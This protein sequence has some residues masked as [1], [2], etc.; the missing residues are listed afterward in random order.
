MLLPS[1]SP[2]ALALVDLL[3]VAIAVFDPG[4]KAPS[5]ANVAW[6]A[7][8]AAIEIDDV[9][10]IG[11]AHH[12]SECAVGLGRTPAYC[13]ATVRP[14]GTRLIVACE[15]I[16]D[17]VI[18]RQLAVPATA[19]VWGGPHAG[20]PDY[21]NQRW[22]AYVGSDPSWQQAIHRDDLAVCTKALAAALREEGST[23]VEARVCAANGLDRW[24]RV[25]FA[26]AGSR[27]VGTAVD[28]HDAHARAERDELL[29]RLSAA[30]ADAETASRLKDQFLAVV[31][32]ELRTPLTTIVL[33]EGILRDEAT[34]PALRAKAL[35]AIRQSALSQS[36][37]VGDLLDLTRASTGKLHIDLRPL[38][39]SSLVREVVDTLAPAARAKQ[40]TIEHRDAVLGVE[41][42]GDP[43]RLHQVL[44]NLLSN[45][46]KFTDPGG[47]IAV[48]LSRQGRSVEISVADTGR[49]ISA[50]LLARVFDPFAQ[51]DDPLTRGAGGLGLGLA[52]A[53]QLVELHDGT[54]AVASEGPGRGATL[55]ITLPALPARAKTAQASGVTHARS[56]PRTRVLVIDDDLRVREALALLLERAGAVVDSADSAAAGRVRIAAQRPDVLVCDIAMPGEDGYSL[57]RG[58]RAAG[59][60]VA[61]IALTAY[62]SDADIE[63]ALAAGFDRHVAKPID[64]ER[65]LGQIDELA[66][67][68]RPT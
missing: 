57:L 8:R 17:E 42:E 27:W 55:T 23:E 29:A 65:L 46:L 26:I 30:I 67:S 36:R 35:E 40:I 62:S 47:R 18:A 7:L 4:S 54:L 37:V 24:H 50:D 20:D 12:I 1:S 21:F 5:L 53:K 3:D 41:V 60:D 58:L 14:S 45:A 56:L 25:R 51:S 38:E 52:I 11:A 28:I 6:R 68:A 64:F 10:Q 63:R 32:H 31:S 43:G 34:D 49:G 2:D 16:T 59:I 48:N 22:F 15:D 39:I 13:A 66:A 61:A 44:D 33:W 19:L 9:V